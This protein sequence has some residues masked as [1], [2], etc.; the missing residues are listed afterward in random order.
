MN[1]VKNGRGDFEELNF[2]IESKRWFEK[3]L[4]LAV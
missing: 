2:E 1:K 3:F 4:R